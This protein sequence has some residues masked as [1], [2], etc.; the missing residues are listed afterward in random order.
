VPLQTPF[1]KVLHLRA[2]WQATFGGKQNGLDKP[3]DDCGN[4]CGDEKFA[5]MPTNLPK[6][7]LD[8]ST[9]HSHNGS[10]TKY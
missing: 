5:K 9:S 7:R 8:D 3:K 2:T 4:I 1:Q 6:I 10:A